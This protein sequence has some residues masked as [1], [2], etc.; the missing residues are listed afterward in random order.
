MNLFK[1]SFRS[2]T[3]GYR[4]SP[5]YQPLESDPCSPGARFACLPAIL[6]ASGMTEKAPLPSLGCKLPPVLGG[7]P[8]RALELIHSLQPVLTVSSPMGFRFPL[9][10]ALSCFLSECDGEPRKAEGGLPDLQSLL[11]K[12]Q[13]CGHLEP[14]S[15]QGAH[16][17]LLCRALAELTDFGRGGG[18]A[19]TQ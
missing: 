18:G 5:G 10:L 2:S 17:L 8:G 6:P 7:S 4:P 16:Q 3:G 14:L 19:G 9:N 15:C 11:E 13:G 12:G 1:G